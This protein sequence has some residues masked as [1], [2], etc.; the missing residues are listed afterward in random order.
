ML[1]PSETDPTNDEVRTALDRVCASEELRSSP[2]LMAF[3]RFVVDAT[4]RGESHLIK[5]YTIAVQALGRDAAFD[6]T[7]DPIVRVQAGRLRR[8]LERYYAGP[9]A[10]DSILIYIPL[11]H[12]VPEFRW[13][14]I[15]AKHSALVA[16]LLRNWR[17]PSQLFST[18]R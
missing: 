4:L 1:A 18:N 11:G 3:L 2:Q 10:A 6:A 9:G 8:A 13:R 7:T 14:Q 15:H 17:N 16:D 12:Y 5:A